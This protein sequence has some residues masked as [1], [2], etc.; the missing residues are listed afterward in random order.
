MKLPVPSM[1]FTA[2][3]KKIYFWQILLALIWA[4]YGTKPHYGFWN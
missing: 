2:P 4:T 1:L 3:A